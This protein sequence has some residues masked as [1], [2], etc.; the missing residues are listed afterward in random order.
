MERAMIISTGKKLNLGDFSP[1][2]KGIP[3]KNDIISLTENEKNHIT[4]ALDFTNWRI[5]GD[6]GAAKLLEIK[7]TTLNARIKKHKIKR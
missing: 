6:K 5:G 2:K 3:Q 4:R 7:R 1:Q